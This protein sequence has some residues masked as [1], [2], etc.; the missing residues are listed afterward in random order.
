MRHT[1]RTGHMNCRVL[2][3]YTPTSIDRLHY[4]LSESGSRQ[5]IRFA[6]LWLQDK[7]NLGN[8]LVQ[9]IGED[10]VHIPKV[11]KVLTRDI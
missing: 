1:R 5:T 4:Y 3:G 7:T 8:V 10:S 11:V 6:A 2:S 9:N